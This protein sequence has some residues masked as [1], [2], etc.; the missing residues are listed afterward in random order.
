MVM[1]V[2]LDFNSPLLKKSIEL[3]IGDDIV[4]MDESDFIISDH[5]HSIDKPLFLVSHDEQA[6][7]KIPFT[8]EHLLSALGEFI[9]KHRQKSK[10]EAKLDRII[11]ELDKKHKLKIEK[12][13]SDY[14]EKI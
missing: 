12:L 7:L 10:E 13:I 14:Y 1:K 4:S 8:K 3:Y 6:T 11:E 2:A 9:Y 5:M